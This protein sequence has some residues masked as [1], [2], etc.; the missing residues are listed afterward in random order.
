LHWQTFSLPCYCSQVSEIEMSDDYSTNYRIAVI[1]CGQCELTGEVWQSETNAKPLTDRDFD[2]AAHLTKGTVVSNRNSMARIEC[3]QTSCTVCNASVCTR[4]TIT[5]M[6]SGNG[7]I[8]ESV[9]TA[10]LGS[11]NYGPLVEFPTRSRPNT[12]S[13]NARC[14]QERFTSTTPRRAFVSSP[15][16]TPISTTY[17]LEKSM[18]T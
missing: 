4:S 1:R 10:S 11:R 3:L 18:G 14:W 13:S 12:I 8:N 6:T 9:E 15:N 2:N 16:Q 5:R 17:S 7:H